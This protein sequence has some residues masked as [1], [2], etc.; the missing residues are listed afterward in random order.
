MNPKEAFN[1]VAGVT[2]AWGIYGYYHAKNELLIYQFRKQAAE[3]KKVAAKQGVGTV[4]ETQKEYIIQT[5]EYAK[6]LSHADF[7]DREQITQY[8]EQSS[9]PSHTQSVATI[10]A[11]TEIH[12]QKITEIRE[13]MKTT[14]KGLVQV[15]KEIFVGKKS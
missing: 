7:T 14:R 6:K 12:E 15:T 4:L 5:D 3:T 10:L 8:G 9:R 13:L 11:R 2:V 1:R